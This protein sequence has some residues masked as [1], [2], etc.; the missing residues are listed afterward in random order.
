MV[1][2]SPAMA[3]TTAL[4]NTGLHG[5]AG[6]ANGANLAYPDGARWRHA[7]LRHNWFCQRSS[8]DYYAADATPATM[9][10]ESRRRAAQRRRVAERGLLR[11]H[12]PGAPLNGVIRSD[13][14]RGG[15]NAMPAE[16]TAA[17][18][19]TMRSWRFA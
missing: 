18:A 2:S 1:V 16:R 7:T 8:V 3:K 10:A 15:F 14:K 4:L 13:A 5:S 9:T 12:R 6:G 17:Y 11:K 19:P